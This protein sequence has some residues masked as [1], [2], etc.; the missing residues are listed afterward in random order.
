MKTPKPDNNGNFV[1]RQSLLKT[2]PLLTV[3]VFALILTVLS[4]ITVF[5]GSYINLTEVIIRTVFCIAVFAISV[6]MLVKSPIYVITSEKIL[7]YGKWELGFSDI[8]SVELHDNFLGMLEIKG[9]DGSFSIFS[10]DISCPLKVFSEIL[11]ERIS[12][13][14]QRNS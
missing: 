2:V 13:Y 1:F 3:A 4:V 10:H 14:E 8:E 7:L 6:F 11:A 5:T 12:V 9:K